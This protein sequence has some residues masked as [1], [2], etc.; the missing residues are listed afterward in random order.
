MVGAWHGAPGHPP[1]SGGGKGAFLAEINQSSFAGG[2][3]HLLG[4]KFLPLASWSAV[5]FVNL[6]PI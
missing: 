2:R 6:E 5:N 3:D 1:A 4:W